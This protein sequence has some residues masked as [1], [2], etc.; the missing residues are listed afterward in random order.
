MWNEK[1]VYEPGWE[2]DMGWE[3]D[4]GRVRGSVMGM[5]CDMDGARAGWAHCSAVRAHSLAT[6]EHALGLACLPNCSPASY[7]SL[8][9][10]HLWLCSLICWAVSTL[11]TFPV[12]WCLLLCFT[13]I[14][15]AVSGQEYWL[16]LKFSFS[17]S[18]EPSPAVTKCRKVL[19]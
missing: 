18:G 5:S 7:G 1:P 10:A 17:R 16:G 12:T 14:R 13:P 2:S 3:N 8:L 9:V 15:M 19:S 4:T 6:M 11:S